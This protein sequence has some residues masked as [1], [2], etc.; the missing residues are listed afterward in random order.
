MQVVVFPGDAGRAGGI[1]VEHLA[2]RSAADLPALGSIAKADVRGPDHMFRP[3]D[4]QR[5]DV[6]EK[7][8]NI[9]CIY[10]IKTGDK[11]GLS[12]PRMMELAAS[13]AGKYGATKF[14][15]TEIRP[16]RLNRRRRSF[17]CV[18]LRR[19]RLT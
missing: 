5:I 1:G 9:V 15:V 10:D 12:L 3:V 6:F 2:G 17:Q 14:L 4:A 7:K 8:K 18:A 13:V 11:R 16:Q 19:C